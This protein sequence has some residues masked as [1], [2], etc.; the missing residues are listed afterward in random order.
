MIRAYKQLFSLLFLTGKIHEKK[1]TF[2]QVKGGE[3]VVKAI[4]AF[5]LS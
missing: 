5:R 4:D 3:R 2:L 1:N